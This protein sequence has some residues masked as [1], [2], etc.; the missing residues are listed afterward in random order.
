MEKQ[1]LE[2]IN[3]A[4][5]GSI[6]LGGGGCNGGL[7]RVLEKQTK[8]LNRLVE[9]IEGTSK[10]AKGG[11]QMRKQTSTPQLEKDLFL[12]GGCKWLVKG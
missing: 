1:T 6:E 11:L 10:G 7:T 4:G 12:S 8:E 3:S 2:G 9:A 5:K